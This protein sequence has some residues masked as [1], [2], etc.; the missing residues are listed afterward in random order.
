MQECVESSHDGLTIFN[1]AHIILTSTTQELNMSKQFT[2][3]PSLENTYRQKEIDKIVMMDIKDQWVVTEKVHGCFPSNTRIMLPDGSH[4]T[5]KEI[6]D[7]KYDGEI[8]SVNAKGELE[9]CKVVDWFYNG[10]TEDWLKIHYKVDGFHGASK[11]VLTLTP[12]HHVFRNGEYIEAS[13]LSVGD[14][15]EVSV[16]SLSLSKIQEQVLIGKM[17]GDGSLI[18]NSVTFGHTKEKEGYVDFTLSCLGSIAG[19]RQK[20]CTSG[21]GSIM[22]RA[23][24]IS[25][26]QISDVFRNWDKSVG[27]IPEITLTPI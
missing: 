24:S 12:N 20:D 23:R 8:L 7:T 15:L 19:N 5:I 2:K 16:N 13:K 22:S 25:S 21:Y 1:L 4:K 27:Y 17:L 10:K 3:F 18:N 26:E 11:R 9:P 14:K 6:V